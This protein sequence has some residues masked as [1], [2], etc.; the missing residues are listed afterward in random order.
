MKS[1][2]NLIL[3]GL[4]IIPIVIYASDYK[5]TVLENNASKIRFNITFDKP[6]IV[7][8]AGMKIARY[9]NSQ[10]VV[11]NDNLLIPKIVKFFN[12]PFEGDINPRI[13]SAKWKNEI[14]KNYYTVKTEKLKT[15]PIN[16]IITAQYLGK[17]GSMPIHVLNLYPVKYDKATATMSW[18]NSMEVE[19]AVPKSSQNISKLSKVS[20]KSDLNESLFINNKNEIYK[21]EEISGLTKSSKLIPDFNPILDKDNVYKLRIKETG[22]Y[23]ITFNDLLDADYP[24]NSVNPLRLS[25]FY[26][27]TEVPIY[28][29]GAADGDFDEGDYFEFWGKKNEKTFLNQFPDQYSDP[30]S[31]ES[32][33]WLVENTTNGRRLVEENGALIQSGSNPI[34]E[35][36]SFTETLHFESDKRA[37]KFGK[38]GSYVDNPTYYLDQW[39]FDGGISAPGSRSYDFNVPDPYE[40]GSNVIITAAFRGKS[41]YE[42]KVNELDGHS[43]EL[44]LRGKDGTARLIGTVDPQDK[45]RDQHMKIITNADSTI[46]L[47]QSLLNNGINHL[48]V[49][50]FQEGVSDIVLLNWFDISYL[51][52]YTAYNNELKF[53]VD[54]SFFNNQYIN[55]GDPIRFNLNGF[56]SNDIDIYKIGISKITN[57]IIKQIIE[58]GVT[59]YRITFQDEIFDPDVEYVAVNND[60][61]LKPVSID[62][63]EPWTT[64]GLTAN[65]RDVNN[66]AEYLIIT[67]NLLY[68]TCDRL[69]TLKEADGYHTE[70]VTVDTIYDV[71]NYGIKSPLAIKEFIKYAAMNW[72]NTYPLQY[73][74]FVGDASYDYK[75]IRGSKT[76]FVPT[77]MYQSVDFGATGSDYWYALLDDDY[78]PDVSIS[79]IPA[80]SNQELNDYINKIENYAENNI[81]PW[82][83]R[84]LFISGR[85]DSGAD[86][87]LLTNQPIFRTQ[88]LRLIDMQL[89]DH[90]FAY[91]LN[92]IKDK[93]LED[94]EDDPNFGSTTDLIEYFDDGVS[95][96]NF[97]GHG[98]GSIWADVN[99]LNLNDVERLNN[100]SRLPFIAS[101]TCFTG[102]Y[103]NPSIDGLAERLILSE[104]KGAIAMLA[105]SGF[106]WKYNDMAVEW[107]L[108]EFLWDGLTFGQAVDLMKIYYLANP[109]YYTENGNF[110]TLSYSTL[111]KTM[112]SQYNLLGDPAL[113]LQKPQESL[114]L[115][116]DN[117]SPIPGDSLK[118]TI[119]GGM[120]SGNG[121]LEVVNRKNL[122]IYSTGFNHQNSGVDIQ[123][124]LADTLE[125]DMLTIKA[126]VTDGTVDAAGSLEIGL[127]KS[128]IKNITSNPIEPKV[129]DSILFQVEIA[130]HSNI[131]SVKLYNF[132]DL[133]NLSTY[134]FNITTRKISETLFES[135]VELPGFTKAGVKLFDVLMRDSA[136][137]E[138]LYRW[139]K[140]TIYDDRPD[141]KIVENT[142]AYTG[143]SKLQIKFSIENDSNENL[144]DIGIAAFTDNGIITDTPFAESVI[145]LESNE[146]KTITMNFDSTTF[147]E[148][149]DFKIALDPLNHFTERNEDNNI[150]EEQLTTD[151]ILIQPAVGTTINGSDNDTITFNNKWKFFVAKDT[152]LQ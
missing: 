117:S 9:N 99:L 44:K 8:E 96:I 71:F 7:D 83:N 12:L 112:V 107:G 45:W 63:Y 69:K 136:G 56:H 60:A 54:E 144:N 65:L 120:A 123:I 18:I 130:S 133:D 3:L 57:G 48:E 74:V 1:F 147:K 94:D 138:Q 121:L 21:T 126:Y 105:S 91:R 140:L 35:P 39:Y 86:L 114:N 23:K 134:N 14:V 150:L 58:N 106:G 101:M 81:G 61:K 115:G 49:D 80:S 24:V 84:S 5:I 67:D 13:I 104:D 79:R 103:E 152:I 102:A 42:Y 129:G 62:P 98:G 2:F 6:Q 143:T 122:L 78:I 88:S 16:S 4:L 50:L 146:N 17:R 52:K 27:G 31:D 97:L 15:L 92:T 89:P 40:S 77:F 116:V 148:N 29:K 149:R 11:T 141:I 55:L 109:I 38:N 93:S 75:G 119:S 145:T 76:D 26:R 135:N 59:T 82:R 36:Y 127:G 90:M 25:L 131:E 46:K 137:V 132:R 110:Y 85:D 124:M 128:V 66:A 87:E 142:L 10:Q 30:F 72:D 41:Y 100:G 108:F 33:Y 118:I 20:G 125:S 28:F 32:I 34:F 70:I 37:E 68:T 22:L 73:V 43:V 151:H 51:R 64:D 47:S 111:Q 139:R 113:K 19:V 95:Y 53:S